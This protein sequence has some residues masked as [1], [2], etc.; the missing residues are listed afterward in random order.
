MN[1]IVTNRP[2]FCFDL[3]A[4]T[5]LLSR[6]MALPHRLGRTVFRPRNAFLLHASFLPKECRNSP[7]INASHLHIMLCSKTPSP[8]LLSPMKTLGILLGAFAA[9]SASGLSPAHHHH[10]NVHLNAFRQTDTITPAQPVCPDSNS[11]S[12]AKNNDTFVIECGIDRVGVSIYQS[13]NKTGSFGNCVDLCANTPTCELV[14]CACCF[15]QRLELIYYDY[16][17]H[18]ATKALSATSRHLYILH[19]PTAASLRRTSTPL[20]SGLHLNAQYVTE[21]ILTGQDSG[22]FTDNTLFRTT[23]ALFGRLKEAM[24]CSLCCAASIPGI[25]PFFLAEYAS[26]VLTCLLEMAY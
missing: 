18:T 11:T 16:R 4:V 14:S 19:P 22:F 24:K 2:Y 3:Q 21:D 23:M 7:D 15:Y 10:A 26:I 13:G 12:Y 17:Q 9:V 25:F 5:E 1:L 6:G 20:T 8:A